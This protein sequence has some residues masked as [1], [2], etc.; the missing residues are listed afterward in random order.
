MEQEDAALALVLDE[1]TRPGGHVAAGTGELADEGLDRRLDLVVEHEVLERLLVELDVAEP[2]D[3][4]VTPATLAQQEPRD[5]LG[6]DV[7]VQAALGRLVLARVQVL[8]RGEPV[9]V[10]AALALVPAAAAAAAVRCEIGKLVRRGRRVLGRPGVVHGFIRAA[11][12]LERA[13][14]PVALVAL[15]VDDDS[16]RH[17][18]R[19]A[20]AVVPVGV[21]RL[22]RQI[23]VVG[24]V[25]RLLVEVPDE[26]AQPDLLGRHR[27]GRHVP[28]GPGEEARRDH[29]EVVDGLLA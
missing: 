6:H 18:A 19:W 5:D 24:L 13:G 7:V 3:V 23:P 21:R 12:G 25:A 9:Q 16:A 4:E 15:A 20:G 26:P 10:L 1:I 17:V 29:G 8:E 28:L 27:R 2:L 11:A 22:L 14:L